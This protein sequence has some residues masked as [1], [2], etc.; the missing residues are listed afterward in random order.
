MCTHLQSPTRV[1]D[2]YDSHIHGRFTA[3]LRNTSTLHGLQV[4]RAR[5]EQLRWCT[6]HH[7]HGRDLW[8]SN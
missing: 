4:Y 1:A 8:T 6:G 3:E 2:L 5:A 7:K